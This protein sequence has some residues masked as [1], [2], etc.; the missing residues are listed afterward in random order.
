MLENK[1]ECTINQELTDSAVYIGAAT[2]DSVFSHQVA[3][4]CFVKCRHDGNLESVTS[5]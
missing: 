4:L 1:C 3:A 5:K 2:A